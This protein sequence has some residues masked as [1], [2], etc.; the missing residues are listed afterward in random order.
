MQKQA[1]QMIVAVILL[2]VF[3]AAY[4]GMHIYNQKQAE[5]ESE[6]EEAE[7]I[8]VVGIKQED[9]TAFSYQNGEDTLE[10]VKEEDTWITKNAEEMS[11]DQSAVKSL[12]GEIASLE[13]EEVVEGVGDFSE[14]GLDSPEN[15]ITVTTAD[16]T[17]TFEIG[18]ENTVTGQYYLQ[19]N[20][21]DILYLIPGS[22]P[23]VFEKTLEDLEAVSEETEE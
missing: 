15:V 4:G 19:K 6:R 7:K 5:K 9:I 2:I 8:T 11:L 17:D 23:S 21:E 14:Y 1:K 10:F 18:M 22:F 20:E 12:I 3:G 16:G 13:A